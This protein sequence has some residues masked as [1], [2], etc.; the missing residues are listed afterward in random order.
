MGLQRLAAGCTR[1]ASGWRIRWQGPGSPGP[2][3]LPSAVPS[4]LTGP[5]A[6]DRRPVRSLRA[7]PGRPTPASPALL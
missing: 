2:R 5:G 3:Q 1:S 7:V 4:M 6:E